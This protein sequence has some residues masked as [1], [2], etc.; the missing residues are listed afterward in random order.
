MIDNAIKFVRG[1]V[2]KGAML[3]RKINFPTI[4]IG[5]SALD[6]P[7]GVY[8]SRVK[9]PFGVYKGALHFGPKSVTGS[10]EPSLEVH[11]LD[12]SGDLYGAQVDVEIFEK[13]REIRTFDNMESLKKQIRLD[14]ESVR[15]SVIK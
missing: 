5:Y 14:V 15:A 3:G 4:N 8:V 11:L 10:D 12:F 2:L 13:I 9:T 1:V 6:L 7:Y